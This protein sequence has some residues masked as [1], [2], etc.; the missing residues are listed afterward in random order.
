MNCP[1]YSNAPYVQIPTMGFIFDHS[2]GPS[3]IPNPYVCPESASG[4]EKVPMCKNCGK[5]VQHAH[6]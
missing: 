1:Q 3:A 2:S 5:V 6:K 4:P